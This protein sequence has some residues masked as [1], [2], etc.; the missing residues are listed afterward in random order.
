VC[1]VVS[2]SSPCSDT[3]VPQAALAGLGRRCVYGAAP[4]GDGEVALR[5][6]G[7]GGAH[8][9]SGE[10]CQRSEAVRACPEVAAGPPLRA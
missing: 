8:G 7:H 9:D 3:H 1:S 5:P 6:S 10:A 2:D 4:K